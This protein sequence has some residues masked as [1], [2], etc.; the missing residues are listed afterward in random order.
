MRHL[1]SLA[2]GFQADTGAEVLVTGQTAMF[3][4][5]SGT[6][7]DALLPYLGLVAGLAFLLLLV[8]FRSVL[9]PLKAALGFPLIVKASGRPARH[10]PDGSSWSA[11]RGTSLR[12]P[13]TT[14][15]PSGVRRAR[16]PVR[17]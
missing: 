9:V 6:L 8:V 2:D 17:K 11:R 5:F 10:R 4:D 12:R 14:R 7:D 15:L 13:V 16:S 1:R 3:I